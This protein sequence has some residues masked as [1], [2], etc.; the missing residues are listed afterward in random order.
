MHGPPRGVLL[1]PAPE[2]PAPVTGAGGGATATLE[3]PAAAPARLRV[4]DLSRRELAVVA[5]MVAIIIALGFYPQPLIHLI[6]PAVAATM[7]DVG[8]DP[9]GV[10][11]QAPVEGTD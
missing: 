2:T 10:S 6:E 1:E 7:S 3:A 11:P 9:A 8:A 5:P 4:R